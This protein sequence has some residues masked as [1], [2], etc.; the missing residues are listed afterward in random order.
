MIILSSLYCVAF[1]VG[2]LNYLYGFGFR[3]V[4]AIIGAIIIAT[5]V[6]RRRRHAHKPLP[7]TQK[8]Q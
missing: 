1:L 8:R 4:L 2:T 7:V 5:I 3:E 6:M